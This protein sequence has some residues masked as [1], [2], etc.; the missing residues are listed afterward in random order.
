MYRDNLT[1]FFSAKV[2][3]EIVKGKKVASFFCETD[4]PGGTMKI[5]VRVA[6][7]EDFHLVAPTGSYVDIFGGEVYKT[8]KDADYDIAVYIRE[9]S[10]VNVCAPYKG[11]IPA[12]TLL[13]K[14]KEKQGA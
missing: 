14:N 10:Q 3:S 2:T 4:A 7:S 9:C 12:G 5:L 11:E 6:L 13:Q 1:I 8:D